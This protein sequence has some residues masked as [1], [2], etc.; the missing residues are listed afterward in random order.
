MSKRDRFHGAHVL[1][2]YLGLRRA[3]VL[4][5][6]WKD[7]DLDAGWLQVTQTDAATRRGTV[8]LPAAKDPTFPPDGANA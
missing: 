2:V 5:L 8:A 3:E 4:S 1:A 7:V 6:R